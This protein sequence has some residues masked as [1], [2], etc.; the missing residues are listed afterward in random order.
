[1]LNSSIRRVPDISR[2]RVFHGMNAQLIGDEGALRAP[3]GDVMRDQDSFPQT[4]KVSH[5]FFRLLA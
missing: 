2:L 1:M 5:G 4:W 3:A